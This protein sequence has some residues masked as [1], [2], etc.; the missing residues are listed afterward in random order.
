MLTVNF[1]GSPFSFIVLFEN[2]DMKNNLKLALPLCSNIRP[3]L[4]Q[5]SVSELM[6]LNNW[7]NNLTFDF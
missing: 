2:D 5:V 1:R 4:S 7:R 6:V 3:Q